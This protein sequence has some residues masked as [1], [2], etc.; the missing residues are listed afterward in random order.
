MTKLSSITP[1][2]V[3]QTVLP[4]YFKHSKFTSFV[5]QL[6]FYGFRKIR[7][8][9]ANAASKIQ[10]D[11]SDDDGSLEQASKGQ[12]RKITVCRFYHEFFQ[13]NRPELLTRI[14]RATKSAEPPTPGQ[15]EHLRHQV[16]AMQERMNA[17]EG[18]FERK[19]QKMKA[20]LEQ[21]YQRRFAMLDASY[22]EL[23]TQVL[24]DR[25]SIG[26][27]A[28]AT[29]QA[30]APSAAALRSAALA[31]DSNLFS[32][33][34]GMGQSPLMLSGLNRG[35]SNGLY[36]NAAGGMNSLMRNTNPGSTDMSTLGMLGKFR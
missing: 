23:L 35:T 10:D 11:D 31:M 8:T 34:G 25:M 24:K 22:K 17:M 15:I 30:G 2:F 13:A 12:A 4:K 16:E 5:R 32:L 36:S 33:G 26:T 20:T 3:T 7:S 27:P 19:L 18:L 29:A 1:P 6:N 9:G 14:T 28:G 21:D